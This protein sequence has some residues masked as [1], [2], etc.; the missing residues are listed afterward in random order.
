MNKHKKPTWYKP[1][2]YIP[3]T[4]PMEIEW[5][6]IKSIRRYKKK[7]IKEIFK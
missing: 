7:R 6:S 3:G 4:M 1:K 2:L 5:C